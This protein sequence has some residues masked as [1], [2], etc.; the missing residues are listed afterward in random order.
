MAPKSKITRYLLGL[1]KPSSHIETT[2]LQTSA[3]KVWLAL[4]VFLAVVGLIVAGVIALLRWNVPL[5]EMPN[6]NSQPLSSEAQQTLRVAPLAPEDYLVGGNLNIAGALGVNKIISSADMLLGTSQY[7]VRLQGS[8]VSLVATNGGATNTF[9]FA[10]PSGAS[11]TILI[12]N[13]SGTVAVSAS[14]PL[15]LDANGNLSCSSCTAQ[16]GDTTITTLITNNF[17]T[18][19]INMVSLT[20]G[21]GIAITEQNGTSTISV[22]GMANQSLSNLSEVAINTSLLPGTNNTI[23]I[24]SGTAAFRSGYFGTSV[25]SAVFD[26]VNT[27][28]L[29]IGTSVASTIVLGANTSTSQGKSLTVNGAAVFK[30]NVNSTASFQ[31]QDSAGVALLNANTSQGILSVGTYVPTVVW[32]TAPVTRTDYVTGANPQGVTR[33]DF[34]GDGWVDLVTSNISSDTVSVFMNNGNGTFAAKVDYATGLSPRGLISAD[35]NGDARPDLAVA[36]WGANTISVL[37]NNG[38][39]IFAAKVDYVTGSRPQYPTSADF[40]GDGIFDLA[41]AHAN[42]NVMSVFMNNSNGTFA[43]KVDYTTGVAGT[44]SWAITAADFNGDARA[45]LAVTNTTADTMA[46]FMNNGN[47]TFAARVDYTT[48][49][50]AYGITAA[51]FNGDARPD[52]AVTNINSNTVSTYSNNG[53]GTFAAKVDYAT[54]LSPAAVTTVDFNNDTKVDLAVANNV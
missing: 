49:S 11:K 42:I 53:N 32:S 46:V 52:L 10:A 31:V 4:V 33:A 12:P 2:T 19:T 38:N 18:T 25:R 39:G 30:N 17:T 27:G 8:D 6:F 20:P 21:N 35:F 45:D 48:G 1:S 26:T 16:A 14:G 24:G 22:T 34:N 15:T 51:D 43:A 23:D 44:T 54:G 9:R 47:G 41:V 5:T 28:Q 40:N 36:N 37:L 50:T 29:S 13:A 7:A 3:R